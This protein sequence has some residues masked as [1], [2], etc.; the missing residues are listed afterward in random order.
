MTPIKTEYT[1]G[2]EIT[3]TGGNE[4]NPRVTEYNWTVSWS[5]SW[6]ENENETINVNETGK[7]QVNAN[8]LT[9]PFKFSSFKFQYLQT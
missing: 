2:E 4:T 3:C 9:A 7:L 6:S 5:W 8:N 1:V